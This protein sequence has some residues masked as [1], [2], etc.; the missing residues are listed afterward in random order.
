M[1]ASNQKLGHGQRMRSWRVAGNQSDRLFLQ[2]LML[3]WSNVLD[4]IRP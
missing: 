4:L 1:Q 2:K 3:M